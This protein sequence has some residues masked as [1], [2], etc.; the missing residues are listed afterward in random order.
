MECFKHKYLR[1]HKGKEKLPT[2]TM[3]A[4]ADERLY[5]WHAFFGNAVCKNDLTVLD[6]SP[7]ISSI[8]NATY[9]LPCEYR[10][11]DE[12]SSKPYWLADGIY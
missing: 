7:L 6:A 3:E 12:V 2:I 10:I 5:I 1:P 9:P 11:M 8:A 4:I